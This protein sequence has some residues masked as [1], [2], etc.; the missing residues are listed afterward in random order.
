MNFATV[1]AFEVIDKEWPLWLVLLGFAGI[2]VLG[3]FVCRK[4]PLVALFIWAWAVF[5]GLRVLSELNDQYVG[6]AIRSEAG[7]A[8]VVLSYASIGAAILLPAIG[9]WHNRV[10]GRKRAKFS[11]S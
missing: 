2:G 8:Y 7:L 11:S 1:I 9:V 3:L 5:G 6:P 10:Q 4:W